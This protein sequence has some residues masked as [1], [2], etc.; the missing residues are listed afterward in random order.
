MATLSRERCRDIDSSFTALD[1][2]RLSLP[3]AIFETA[4]KSVAGHGQR[5]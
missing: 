1:I 3:T 4:S 5:L 2:P